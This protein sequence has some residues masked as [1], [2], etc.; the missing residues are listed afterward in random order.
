MKPEIC[1]LFSVSYD[2]NEGGLCR[3]P[4]CKGFLPREFPLDNQFQCRRCGA[5]LET[6]PSKLDD[7]DEEEDTDYE[8]GGRICLVPPERIKIVVSPTSTIKIRNK[9]K[10][11]KWAMGDGFSRRVWRD[12][13]GE[14]I[15]IGPERLQINDSRIILITE[16]PLDKEAELIN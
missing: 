2:E 4:K 3:C 6:L 7:P 14:F 15:E 12:L 13:E 1:S 9:R 10:T 11:N 16:N 8:W 5:I